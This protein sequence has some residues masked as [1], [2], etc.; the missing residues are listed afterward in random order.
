MSSQGPPTRRI[1][2][3]LRKPASSSSLRPPTTPTPPPTRSVGASSRIP[4][5]STTRPTATGTGTARVPSAL[6]TA[7]SYSS[8]TAQ[9]STPTP[10]SRTSPLKPPSRPPTTP[11]RG[12]RVPARSPIKSS[13]RPPLPDLSS[14]SPTKPPLSLKEQIALKRAEAKK[15]Q[16]SHRSQPSIAG[17]SVLGDDDEWNAGKG[18]L[19]PGEEEDVLGRRS[20]KESIE[21]AR[22]TGSLNLT[23]RSLS[24]LPPALFSIHLGVDPE[25]LPDQPPSVDDVKPSRHLA[26][27]E[28]V[29]LTT[30]KVRDNAITALQPELALFGS[31]KVLDLSKNQ[32]SVLPDTFGELVCLVHLDLSENKFDQFPDALSYLPLL[33]WLDLSHNALN[34]I[35]FAAP[36]SDFGTDSFF[37][38]SRRSKDGGKLMALKTLILANNQLTP[39]SIDPANFPP[40]SVTKLDLS[41]NPLGQARELIRRL[42][43]SLAL[44]ELSIKSADLEEGTFTNPSDQPNKLYSSLHLLDLSENAWIREPEL[45]T[46]FG[47]LEREVIIGGPTTEASSQTAVTVRLGSKDRREAWEVEAQE[48]GKTKNGVPHES[49]QVEVAEEGLGIGERNGPPVFGGGRKRLDRPKPVEKE[50]WEV[51]I[52]EGLH[53]EAGRLRK[54]L[55][56]VKEEEDKAATVEVKEAPKTTLDK[57]FDEQ[58]RTVSLPASKR[59]AHNRHASWA[60]SRSGFNGA[61]TDPNVPTETLP[62]GVIMAHSWGATLRAL[63]LSNRRADVAFALGSGG[64]TLRLDKVEEILLDGCGLSDLVRVK[65]PGEKFEETKGVFEILGGMFPAIATLDLSENNL[66]HVSGIVKLFFPENALAHGRGLKVLRLKGNSIASVEGLVEVAERFGRGESDGW[67]GEE[68]DIRDNQ[69]PKLPPVLGLLQVDVLLVEGNAFR[70]PPRTIWQREGTQGLLKYLRESAG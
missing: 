13:P 20:V 4:S 44:R 69:I 42:G 70:V 38:F 55:T 57:Y 33:A 58:S 50:Q 48:R 14:E 1:Q 54:R 2:S 30:L 63:H 66:T 6:H 52:D 40:T 60:M 45:R 67:R 35:S 37:G 28:A 16:N 46:Y 24:H 17:D 51:D 41:G 64:D 53:T 11:V 61:P 56:E 34:G 25:P 47:P 59:A 26:Y 23:S 8:L 65:R 7:K 62:L 21:R 31:L 3:T 22:E 32:L 15:L 12:G 68:V 43:E 49:G 5:I 9:A 19:N 36:P 18:N 10:T 39:S 29:D 27:Y